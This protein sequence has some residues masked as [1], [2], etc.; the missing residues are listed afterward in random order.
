VSGKPLTFFYHLYGV[1]D[2]TDELSQA[3]YAVQC[4][5]AESLLPEWCVTQSRV[6][7]WLDR[8][9]SRRLPAVLGYGIRIVAV[10]V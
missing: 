3:G 7:G 1:R 2:L 5:E 9:M 10:P 6:L 4:C 8:K